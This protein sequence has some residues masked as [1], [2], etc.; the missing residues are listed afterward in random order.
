MGIFLSGIG[1]KSVFLISTVPYIFRNGYQV[2]FSE[3]PNSDCMIGYIVPEWVEGKPTVSD[4]PSVY[5]SN[6]NLPKTII[7]LPLRPEKVEAVKQELLEVH[8]ELL[9]FLSKIKRL[10]VQGNSGKVNKLD[11]NSVISI[12]SASEHVFSDAKEADARVVHLSV[13]EKVGATEETCPLFHNKTGV[14]SDA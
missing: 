3:E 14:S 5:E 6:Q 10:S 13:Q 7:I 4:I 9:L 8:P 12:S 11:H 1:F 2:R